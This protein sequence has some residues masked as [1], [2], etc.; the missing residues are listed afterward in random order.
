MTIA[1][2][3]IARN[4]DGQVLMCLRG[5]CTCD[6]KGRKT[7]TTRRAQIEQIIHDLNLVSPVKN[8]DDTQEIIQDTGNDEWINLLGAGDDDFSSDDDDNGG[9]EDQGQ[10]AP[11]P[12]ASPVCPVGEFQQELRLM[13]ADDDA[14]EKVYLVSLNANWLQ[15]KVTGR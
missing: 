8:G 10:K 4:S 14:A 13:C 11:G 3:S 7:R 15:V 5:E 6:G 2:G 9:G 1:A 12:D